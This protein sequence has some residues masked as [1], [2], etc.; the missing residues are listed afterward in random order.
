[1][2]ETIVDIER[3]RME[4]QGYTTIVSQRSIDITSPVCLVEIGLDSYILAGAEISDNDM[5]HNQHTIRIVSPTVAFQGTER[6][7]AS[8]GNAGH[9]LFRHH[10][11]VKRPDWSDT[12]ELI[13]E[14]ID[15]KVRPRIRLDFITI[16][17]VK[18]RKA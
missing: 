6:R 12:G 7:L 2:I 9:L 16:S 4:A 14:T 8:L 10:I 15:E 13:K 3:R 11:L 1:M 5:M 18:R 17:P